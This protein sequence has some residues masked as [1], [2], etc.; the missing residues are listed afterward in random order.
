M[1]RIKR[2]T[3]K[4]KNFIRNDIWEMELEELSKA[5]ARFIKY[6]KVMLI[7]I[8]TFANEKIGF[9]AVALSFFSTMSAMKN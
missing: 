6:V 9:Q 3:Y 8:K 7:T 5:K 1:G 2:N 4:V